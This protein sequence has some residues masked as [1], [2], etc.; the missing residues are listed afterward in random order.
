MNLDSLC[1]TDIMT[2][3]PVVVKRDTEIDEIIDVMLQRVIEL[4]P[5]VDDDKKSD[6]SCGEARHPEG[7]AK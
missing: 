5:V 1:A 3:N 7:K 2:R 4:V 6:R